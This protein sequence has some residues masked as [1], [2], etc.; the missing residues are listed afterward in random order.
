MSDSA[1]IEVSPSSWWERRPAALAAVLSEG[2]V[3]GVLGAATV[4][5]WFFGIDWSH[6]RPLYTPTVLGLALFRRSALLANPGMIDP[7]LTMTLMFTFVHG[8]I[9]ALMGMATSRLLYQIERSPNVL[10]SI[11]LLAVAL[12]FFFL[13]FALTTAAPAMDA[14]GWREVLLGNLLASV[15]MVTYLWR[16]HP[17]LHPRQ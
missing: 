11:V 3:A 10:V 7:S 16:R 5:V 17:G 13:A 9:F 2:V 6:G 8:V 1:R 15:S 4:A 12:E 14:L